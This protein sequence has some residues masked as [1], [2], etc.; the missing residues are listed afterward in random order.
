MTLA[1][2]ASLSR[3]SSVLVGELKGFKRG[4][5]LLMCDIISVVLGATGTWLL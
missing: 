2:L 3:W 1:G 5:D 4:R